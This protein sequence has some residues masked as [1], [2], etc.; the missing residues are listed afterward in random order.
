MGTDS[1]QDKEN[2]NSISHIELLR[3]FHY[4]PSTGIFTCISPN[5]NRN[6]LIAGTDDG[7]GYLQIRLMK[8]NYRLHRLA[9]FYVHGYYPIGQIDHLNGVRSDNRLCNLRVVA[10]AENNQNKHNV[11]SDSESGIS[12][13]RKRKDTG[14]WQAQ[15]TVNKKQ[16]SLGCFTTPEAAQAA[17]LA[18]KKQF[19]PFQHFPKNDNA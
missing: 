5:N 7:A 17:F 18:A 8:K 19:H 15:I 16:R 9:W 10:L 11:R 4:D 3:R 2:M 12:G 1:H 6:K 14:K 13:I